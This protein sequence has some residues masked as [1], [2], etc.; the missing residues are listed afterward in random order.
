MTTK[1]IN[2][3][4]AEAIDEACIT[5]DRAVEAATDSDNYWEG[6]VRDAFAQAGLAVHRLEREP[7][8]PVWIVWLKVGL[9]DF[10]AD[11]KLASRHIRK[12]LAKA[13]LKIRAGELDVLERRR[14]IVKT[15]FMFGSQLPAV[16]LM[17]I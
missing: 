5:I 14:G 3:L 4:T 1:P 9:E 7:F 15:A 2:H 16:D 6:R 13:G 17:G 10:P 12:A 11:R 8:H